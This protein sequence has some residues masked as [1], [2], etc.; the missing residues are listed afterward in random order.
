MKR[1]DVKN[2]ISREVRV[3]YV[4]DKKTVKA[5]GILHSADPVTEV[6]EV[7]CSNKE[8]VFVHFS[9]LRHFKKKIVDLEG[10]F[11][12]CAE[13]A[14]TTEEAKNAFKCLLE[15][16]KALKFYGDQRSWMETVGGGRYLGQI[17][18]VKWSKAQEAL[19]YVEENFL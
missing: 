19:T 16:Y 6:A 9:Q 10:K 4:K 5:E 8:R 15:S 13:Q 11:K 12:T 18:D 7:W 2:H 1:S 3:Y 17:T 14:Y